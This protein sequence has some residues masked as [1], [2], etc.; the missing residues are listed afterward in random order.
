[1]DRGPPRSGILLATTGPGY[2][3]SRLGL[4]NIT[5][6]DPVGAAKK[7]A[8]AT[9]VLLPPVLHAARWLLPLLLA[10]W[11]VVSSFGRTVVL[12]RADPSLKSR[13]L[14][15]MALQTIRVA[16]LGGSFALWF[17]L[18]HAAGASTVTGPIEAG[19][20]PNILL[21][22]TVSI[23]STLALFS[24]WAVV[25]WALGIAPLLAMLHGT[26]A[27]RS[28]RDALRLGPLRT[29]L[30]EINLVLGIVKIAL[31]VLAMVFSA[32]PCRSRA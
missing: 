4:E 16:A 5:V 13:P 21:Y 30:I 12:R 19:R 8:L 25:S 23:V 9:A 6:V 29:K 18:L 26:D 15:L 17:F 20:E 28:L 22:C 3:W 10:A 11:I 27:A 1:M 2:E 14:T 31:L 7:L 32:T 24:L